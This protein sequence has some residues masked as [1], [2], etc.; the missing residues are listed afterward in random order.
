MVGI[1][2]ASKKGGLWWFRAKKAGEMMGNDGEN[3]GK[4]EGLLV[5][6][7]LLENLLQ[8]CLRDRPCHSNPG[9]VAS[10]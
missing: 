1:A 3:D 9:H 6:T 5:A 10:G 4:M 7:D 8:I 2:A